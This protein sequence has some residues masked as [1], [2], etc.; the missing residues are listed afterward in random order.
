MAT[1]KQPTR[2]GGTKAVRTSAGQATVATKLKG[3]TE[4]MLEIQ[5]E[6]ETELVSL[7]KEIEAITRDTMN[8]ENEIRRQNLLKGTLEAE[9]KAL[10]KELQQLERQN[11]ADDNERKAAEKE[12]QKLFDQ[13]VQVRSELE[14]LENDVKRLRTENSSLSSEAEGLQATSNKLKADVDRLTA[15][16]E[17]YLKSIAKFKEVREELLP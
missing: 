6:E 7:L 3:V 13:N 16:R 12:R 9:Q 14:L 10:Q 1:K 15:L 2:S 4:K 11:R 17:E 5:K 8:I